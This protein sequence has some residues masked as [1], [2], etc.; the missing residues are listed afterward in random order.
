MLNGDLNR[1]HSMVWN[2][3]DMKVH[4]QKILDIIIKR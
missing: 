3:E 4:Q 2:A 1:E